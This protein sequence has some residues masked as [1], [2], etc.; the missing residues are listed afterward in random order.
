M[1]G[2]LICLRKTKYCH[3]IK[4]VW[5]DRDKLPGNFRFFYYLKILFLCDDFSVMKQMVSFVQTMPCQA[6]ST[7]TKQLF[8]L[9]FPNCSP[10]E[11]ITQLPPASST[12]SR[13][14]HA[15]SLLCTDSAFLIFLSYPR[16]TAGKYITPLRPCGSP[17]C[18]SPPCTYLWWVLIL[19]LEL[20][21]GIPWHR[22]GYHTCSC[23]RLSSAAGHSQLFPTDV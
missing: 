11:L 13:Q 22:S 19:V 6:I 21:L 4:G 3:I 18:S 15:A 2:L 23:P 7:G 17:A 20:K 12:G 16:E 9:F 8:R 1:Y 10:G 5:G 14:K